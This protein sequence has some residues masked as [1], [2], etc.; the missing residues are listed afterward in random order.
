MAGSEKFWLVH[1]CWI[2]VFGGP[3][4]L[5]HRPAP[6]YAS[7]SWAEIVK[8]DVVRVS[9]ERWT[10]ARRTS[11]NPTAP[12]PRFLTIYKWNGGDAKTAAHWFEQGGTCTKVDEGELVRERLQWGISLSD[13]EPPLCGTS[14]HVPRVP[15]DLHGLGM[16]ECES[17]QRWQGSGSHG[18]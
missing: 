1:W 14:S 18:G 5:M 6:A 3:S 4:P 8:P 16:I 7:F 17:C 10:T 11:Q 13:V 12:Q 15:S 2:F 9:V